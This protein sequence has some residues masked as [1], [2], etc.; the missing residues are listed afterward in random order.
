MTEKYISKS[1]CLENVIKGNLPI[2]ALSYK[3]DADELCFFAN[4]NHF[5]HNE[6]VGLDSQ[7]IYQAEECKGNLPVYLD[8]DVIH[9][10]VT[11]LD[12]E[13]TGDYKVEVNYLQTVGKDSKGTAVRLIELTI[14]VDFSLHEDFSTDFNLD[15]AKSLISN[16]DLGTMILNTQSDA[17]FSVRKFD[18]LDNIIKYKLRPRGFQPVKG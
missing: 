8:T 9:P 6:R 15:T 7:K 17:S 5:K 10:T 11:Y 2:E 16:S 18:P 1:V 3:Q 4:P 13:G 12:V 14:A